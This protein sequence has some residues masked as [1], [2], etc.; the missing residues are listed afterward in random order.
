VVV[1]IPARMG[2]SRYPG[3]PLER[4][5]GQPMVEHVRRRALL[6]PGIA[7]VVVATCDRE[8]ESAVKAA[9]GE[10]VMTSS[11]HTRCTDRV[12]E[13]MNS[14]DGDIVAIVQGDEPLLMPDA[15]GAVVAPLLADKNLHCTNLLS[16]LES[17]ADFDNP[18]IVKAVCDQRG[19]LLLLTRAA[20]P[21]FRERVEVPVFRQTG[22]MGFSVEFL[23][24]YSRMP[25]TPLE[26]AESVDM[27]RL[28]ENGLR[29]AGVVAGYPTLGVDRPGD[30]PLAE[31]ALTGDATQ[32][33]LHERAFGSATT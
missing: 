29:I 11:S 2:S 9:G 18:N 4:I 26:R 32:R 27:L 33:A 21:H 10:V 28:L 20:V 1:V 23:H 25:E 8:I 13:A 30:V 14:I 17:A 7:R 6:A 22:I 12:E 19:D 3:K 15:I 16:P 24:E 31:A 5:L